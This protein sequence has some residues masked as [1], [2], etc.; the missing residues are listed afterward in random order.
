MP[1]IGVDNV[2]FSVDWPYEHCQPC[3][4]DEACAAIDNLRAVVEQLYGPVQNEWWEEGDA[5]SEDK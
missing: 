1:P 4:D 2:L 3:T 5:G